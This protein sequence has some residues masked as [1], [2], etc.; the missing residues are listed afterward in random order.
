VRWSGLLSNLLDAPIDLA[1]GLS[2]LVG[3]IDF[4]GSAD[5]TRLETL[6]D[7]EAVVFVSLGG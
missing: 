5:M 4:C 6:T 2:G 1:R 7:D 3:L